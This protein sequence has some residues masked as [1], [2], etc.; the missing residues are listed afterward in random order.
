MKSGFL[1]IVYM[2]LQTPVDEKT[3]RVRFHITVKRLSSD[4]PGAE[5]P[6]WVAKIG[7]GIVAEFMN[8]KV[9]W[10]H[11]VYRN[12]PRLAENEGPVHEFRRWARQ[13]YASQSPDAQ[14][15]AS[16]TPAGP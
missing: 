15:R 7:A 2:M 6:E 12:R 1:N 9:I 3:I 13:F 8:D 10:D 5:S 4:N 11:K 14:A 16:A